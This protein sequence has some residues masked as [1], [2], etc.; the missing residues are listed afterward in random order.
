[1]TLLQLSMSGMNHHRLPL[2]SSHSSPPKVNREWWQE[3]RHFLLSLSCLILLPSILN[4][5]VKVDVQTLPATFLI[6]N[7]G[8]YYAAS[9][10]SPLYCWCNSRSIVYLT[11]I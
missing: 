11:I 4:P 9:K 8:C 1:M 3:D 10:T 2:L 6:I 5:L 7:Y